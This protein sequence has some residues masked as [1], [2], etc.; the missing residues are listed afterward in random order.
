MSNTT[1]Y[2]GPTKEEEEEFPSPEDREWKIFPELNIGESLD[3]TIILGIE[4]DGERIGMI[5][6]PNNEHIIWLKERIQTKSRN[7]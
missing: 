5:R 6:V 4:L 2:E 7:K 3:G 1:G